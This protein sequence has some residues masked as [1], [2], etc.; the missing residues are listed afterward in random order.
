VRVG[1]VDMDFHYSEYFGNAPQTGYETLLHDCFLG[2]ATLFP[3]ADT[4]EVGWNTVQ[5]ILDVW[6]ALPP[7][8]LPIY[9]AGSWGPPEADE[10]IERDGYKWRNS[11]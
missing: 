11:C 8:G 7:N 10:L 6:E 1:T 2:D 5:P 3:R 4:V 9:P